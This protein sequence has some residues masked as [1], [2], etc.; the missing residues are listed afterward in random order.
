MASDK[1]FRQASKHFLKAY[2]YDGF[3]HMMHIKSGQ[4]E[5]M[6]WCEAHTVKIVKEAADLKRLFFEQ[7]NSKIL[8]PRII[9]RL[10]RKCKI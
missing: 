10:K 4:K 3:L 2:K 5:T 9:Q 6:A 7:V 1:I 8:N